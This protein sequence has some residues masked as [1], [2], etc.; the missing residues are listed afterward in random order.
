MRHPSSRLCSARCA[1]PSSCPPRYRRRQ[2][3]NPPQP[4]SAPNAASRRSCR[5]G[6][7]DNGRCHRQVPVRGEGG[8]MTTFSSVAKLMASFSTCLHP[9]PICFTA[10]PAEGVPPATRSRRPRILRLNCRVEVPAETI[11]RPGCR[12]NG[13]DARPR[14]DQSVN[15]PA[16]SPSTSPPTENRAPPGIVTAPPTVIA[17]TASAMSSWSRERRRA[18]PKRSA[19]AAC[20]ASRRVVAVKCA[21]LSPRRRS[22]NRIFPQRDAVA[23]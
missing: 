14:T 1:R 9:G 2:A 12:Q 15:S 5:P 6:R 16:P 20:A 4:R 17:A 11:S 23:A 22:S 7:A 13:T 18:S 10:T 8:P 19:R 21:A 3:Q